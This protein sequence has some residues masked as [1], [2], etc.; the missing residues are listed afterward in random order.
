MNRLRLALRNVRRLVEALA[1][2]LEPEARVESGQTQP[3]LF[4]QGPGDQSR[5]ETPTKSD[6]GT[7]AGA[8]QP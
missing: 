7:V 6:Y 2:D 8:R 5:H 4:G 1:R 3:D